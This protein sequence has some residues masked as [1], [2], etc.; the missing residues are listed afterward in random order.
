MTGGICERI[1]GRIP[2]RFAMDNH[3]KSLQKFSKESLEN[4]QVKYGIPERISGEISEIV[5]QL[6]RILVNC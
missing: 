6:Q 5:L 2:N 3:K 1:L 4:F